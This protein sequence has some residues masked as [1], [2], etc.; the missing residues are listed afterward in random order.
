MDRHLNYCSLMNSILSSLRTIRNKYQK[1]IMNNLSIQAIISIFHN[2]LG[3]ST[4]FISMLNNFTTIAYNFFFFY[5]IN[6]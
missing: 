6:R 3:Y 1:G 2:L 4:L 5:M